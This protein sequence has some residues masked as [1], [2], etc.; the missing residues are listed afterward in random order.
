M[1]NEFWHSASIPSPGLRISERSPEPFAL[2]AAI[3]VVSQL[4]QIG[5]LSLFCCKRYSSLPRGGKQ[6]KYVGAGQ[7][8]SIPNGLDREAE[9]GEVGDPTGGDLARGVG[10]LYIGLVFRRFDERGWVS[11]LHHSKQSSA[12][13][14]ESSKL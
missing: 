3:L 11:K 10:P 2:S 13:S 4:D 9:Y 5:G 14:L 6:L 7:G 8:L 1:E 12:A